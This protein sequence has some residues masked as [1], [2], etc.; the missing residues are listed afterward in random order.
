M[1][2][3]IEN[4]LKELRENGKYIAM[5]LHPPIGCTTFQA[6]GNRLYINEGRDGKFECSESFYDSMVDVF[7]SRAN[8]YNN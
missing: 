6:D 1:N 2:T 5:S 8:K 3:Q 7:D 4:T